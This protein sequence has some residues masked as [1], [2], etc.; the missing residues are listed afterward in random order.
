M[1]GKCSSVRS[2]IAPVIMGLPIVCRCTL[3]QKKKGQAMWFCLLVS[4]PP[5][6]TDCLIDCLP[7]Q[8]TDWL[9]G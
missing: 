9:T 4:L 5:C 8:L 3:W 2:L 1:L 6:V 7:Y